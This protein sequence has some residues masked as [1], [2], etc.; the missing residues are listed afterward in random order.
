LFDGDNLNSKFKPFKIPS[1]KG[2]RT[3]KGAAGDMRSEVKVSALML[4]ISPAEALA[5]K[6]TNESR[7]KMIDS[8]IPTLKNVWIW[9]IEKRKLMP[10]KNRK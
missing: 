9:D 4:K 5:K 6:L 1:G 10:K 8:K 7:K 2:K 3:G